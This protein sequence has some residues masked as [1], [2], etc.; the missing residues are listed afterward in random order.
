[1]PARPASA[2]LHGGITSCLCLAQKCQ[3]VSVVGALWGGGGLQPYL[4]VLVGGHG[5]ER[6]LWEHVGAEGCVFGTKSIVLICLHDVEPRLVLVH[7]VEDDLEEKGFLLSARSPPHLSSA[8]FSW[9]RAAFLLL[10]IQTTGAEPRKVQTSQVKK[11]PRAPTQPLCSSTDA[12]PGPRSSQMLQTRRY[13]N[14]EGNSLKAPDGSSL[15][16]AVGE[17]CG[18]VT[19]VAPVAVVAWV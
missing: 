8:S 12:T 9:P 11:S 4:V 18:V 19:A 15:M 3:V 1:M 5:D 16:V 10:K 13:G 6:S 2:P 17:A 14:G 7:G